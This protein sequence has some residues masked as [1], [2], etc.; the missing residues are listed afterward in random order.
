MKSRHAAMIGMVALSAVSLAGCTGEVQEFEVG[1]CL[2]G[3]LDAGTEVGDLPV[4]GCDKEHEGEVY[5]IEETSIEEFDAVAI[6]EA[7]NTFCVGKFEEYVGLAYEESQLF[8]TYLIPSAESWDA[9]DRETV[10]IVMPAEDTTT[11]SLK[12]AAA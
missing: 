8:Y 12:G 6:D 5:A 11:G 2:N 4:V 7:A 1:Q 9:G 10:C 3:I